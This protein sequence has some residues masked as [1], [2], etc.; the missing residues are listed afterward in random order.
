MIDKKIPLQKEAAFKDI[1][2]KYKGNSAKQQ[3]QRFL[4][5]LK[6]FRLNTYEA[7]RCL[8]IYDPPARMLQL[9]KQGNHIDTVWEIIED[10]NG[11][12]HRVGC[13][14]LQPQVLEEV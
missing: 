5:A 1:C 10:E 13:Y 11:T 8:S 2:E 4:E 9:R 7:S 6:R 3:C 14:V 12:K